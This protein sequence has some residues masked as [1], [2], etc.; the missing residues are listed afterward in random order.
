MIQKDPRLTG[1]TDADLEE[2]FRLAMRI[3]DETDRAHRAILEI[4][5]MRE[6]LK[7]RGNRSVH[8]RARGAGSSEAR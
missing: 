7:Q 3:R 1:V 6:Q 8:R 4:R 5:S 2:Q